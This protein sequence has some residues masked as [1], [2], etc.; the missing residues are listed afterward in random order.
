[1]FRVGAV[2]M[3]L[4]L[5]SCMYPYTGPYQPGRLVV[6]NLGGR[7]LQSSS[8]YQIAA[9]S[10]RNYYSGFN[11]SPYSYGLRP[12]PVI[13]QRTVTP[14]RYG[15]W[16]YSPYRDVYSPYGYGDWGAPYRSGM[17]VSSFGRPAFGYGSGWGYNPYCW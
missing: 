2:G 7:P 3:A 5:T 15:G 1:M 8:A 4:S 11:G 6:G 16:G 14:Y 13:V 10:P 12:R 9:N 17:V